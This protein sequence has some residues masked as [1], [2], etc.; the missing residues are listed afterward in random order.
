MTSERQGRQAGL[1]LHAGCF[2][3]G[4]AWSLR[5]LVLTG[6][7]LLLIATPAAQAEDDKQDPASREPVFYPALPDP[8]RVQHLVTLTGEK[9]M[10]APSSAFARF[11]LGDD[12]VA[13]QL[14][15][16]YGMAM[17]EGKLYV[18][19]TG[20]AGV[21][22]F[23]FV[24]KQFTYPVSMSNGQMRRPINI[25][26]DGDG[27]KYVT[28]AGRE[29]ILVYDRDDRYVTAFG[30]AGLF[31]PTDLA[32]V[33]ERLYLTDV[34]HHQVHVLDKRSG[35]TLFV[36]G[37]AGSGQG[38][39]FHPTNIVLGPDGDLYVSETSNFRVQRFTTEG[40]SVRSY[41][42]VGA[43][44][45]SFARPKGIAVDRDGRIYVGDA[46][47]ENV[48]LFD[49]QGKLLLFFGQGGD[50]P[51]RMHLPAGVSLDY[52]NVDLFRKYAS[53]DFQIEY[54]IL[55][56]SQFGPNKVD[57]YGFGRMEGKEYPAEAPMPAVAGR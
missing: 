12:D 47:F 41:G 42:A 49:S 43:T 55:V 57:V 8:P 13:Q 48:Q 25:R 5:R 22:V 10:R 21:A 31:R 29:Q 56:T 44:P 15:Q 11:V 34:L 28:D 38:E 36:F 27:T 17:F 26:I 3:Q 35:K 40:K 54:L 30:K 23:D 18:V 9:D 20:A 53:A 33:G 45:G 46:A 6:L 16:P 1:P 51:R 39:L 14:A 2:G 50:V 37:K 32:I 7:S 4:R 52:D 19:D 24:K